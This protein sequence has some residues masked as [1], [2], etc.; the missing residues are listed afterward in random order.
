M[1]PGVTGANT[2]FRTRI[3]G[4]LNATPDSFSGDGTLDLDA[5]IHRGLEMAAAGADILDVGGESSRPFCDPVSPDA[6][7]KRVIPVIRALVKEIQIPISIDTYHC[8]TAKAAL[9]AGATII[10]DISGFR[11]SGMVRLAAGSGAY[12]VIMHMLGKPRDMQ[13]N[14]QYKD[15]VTEVTEYLDRQSKRLIN[16]GVSPDRIILDPGIGFGKTVEDNLLLLRHLDRI[17]ALG[18]PVLTGPS[19]KSFIGTLLSLP[20]DQ[21]LEGTLGAVVTAVCHGTDI[22]RVHDVKETVRA[23]RI[24]DA[25][26]GQTRERK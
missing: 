15:V 18:Y 22:V 25:I 12:A 8:E 16:A 5:I 13:E 1:T 9:D 23:V 10:N 11:D 24:T 4:I 2:F 26:L 7:C 6:E 14:P 19:R 17:R 3:M 21:R 20:V